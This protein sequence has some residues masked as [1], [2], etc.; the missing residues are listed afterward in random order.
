MSKPLVVS[1]P[2]RLGKR[3]ALRRLKTGLGGV[4]TNFGH[5]FSVEEAV[6]TGSQVRFRLSALGQ[7]ANGSIAVA[8]EHVHLEVFLPELLA[9][10]G[11]TLQP[12][13]RQEAVLMLEKK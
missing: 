12:L 1:I 3:E 13:I 7:D 6:W 2:H 9:M 11:E 8:E 5:L 10:L 4:R